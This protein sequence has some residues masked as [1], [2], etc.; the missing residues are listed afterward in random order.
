M[1]L[2]GTTVTNYQSK[3]RNIREERRS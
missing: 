3:L 2:H 1:G